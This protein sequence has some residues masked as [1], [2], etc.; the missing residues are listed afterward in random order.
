MKFA[1]QYA[2][3]HARDGSIFK[4][5][6]ESLGLE[7]VQNR[8]RRYLRYRDNWLQEHGH[9]VCNFRANVNRFAKDKS[10]GSTEFLTTILERET[11]AGQDGN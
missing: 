11:H 3:D 5:L 10:T 2:F 4:G 6:I 1:T 8:I 9:T 7:E